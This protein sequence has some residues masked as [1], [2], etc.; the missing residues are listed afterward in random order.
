MAETVNKT[1][2][3][4]RV[5]LIIPAVPGQPN[6]D[7]QIGINGVNYLIPRGEEVEV[8]DYVAEE[9]Q[10]SYAMQMRE[11]REKKKMLAQAKTQV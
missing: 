1:N 8:P 4:D 10:R 7:V 9:Y 2:K 5:K 11:H 6:T 3:P